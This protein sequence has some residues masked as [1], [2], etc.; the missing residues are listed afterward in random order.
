MIEMIDELYRLYRSVS[1][2]GGG[3]LVFFFFFVFFS[4]WESGVQVRPVR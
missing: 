2:S 3:S 1:S 4:S